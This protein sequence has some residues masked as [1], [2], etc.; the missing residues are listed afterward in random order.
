MIRGTEDVNL[1]KKQNEMPLNSTLSQQ[2]FGVISALTRE[3]GK[4]PR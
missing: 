1:D 2:I 3:Y 4:E